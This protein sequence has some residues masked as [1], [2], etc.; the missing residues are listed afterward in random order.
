M[1]CTQTTLQ[2]MKLV[3]AMRTD[4]AVRQL[5][6]SQLAVM[7]ANEAGIAEDKDVECLH[8]YRVALRRARVLL[9]QLKQVYRQ[10]D[11]ERL[12]QGLKWL[13]M[14]SGPCRDLD[15]WLLMWPE[16][17]EMLNPTN[18]QHLEALHEYLQQQRQQQHTRLLKHL[19]ARRYQVIKQQW[20]A[21]LAADKPARVKYA[22]RPLQDT[23]TAIIYHWW[24]KVMTQ[25]Q[26]IRHDSPAE[27]FHRL[28][29][30][31]KKLRYLLGFFS[32]LYA[33]ED[34]A[35]FI[36]ELKK[37]Q[38]NLGACQDAQV[39]MQTLDKFIALMRKQKK[40]TADIEQ[41]VS[42]L[43]TQLQWQSLQHRAEFSRVFARFSRPELQQR[44]TAVF[45]G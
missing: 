10:R 11:V 38:N 25:G 18:R 34:M 29:I 23:A 28:R 45:G 8:A 14:I 3:G 6:Q 15:V 30:S 13:G 12:Q 26:K 2:N 37:L 31:A 41:S 32:P 24:Q 44:F 39:Q 40:L 22:A 42:Q 16:Y 9:G 20:Q 27:K 1:R 5:L 43:L 7:R 36:A 33:Q 4:T 19:H 17:L 21:F 35:L